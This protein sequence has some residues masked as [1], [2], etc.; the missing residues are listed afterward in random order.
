MFL[1][2]TE[3]LIRSPPSLYVPPAAR[4]VTLRLAYTPTPVENRPHHEATTC[5]REIDQALQGRGKLSSD[6][7]WFLKLLRTPLLPVCGVHF[8][9]RA[10]LLKVWSMLTLR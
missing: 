1:T 2:L 10:V 9:V 3:L 5:L 6:G 8:W 7:V 4:G